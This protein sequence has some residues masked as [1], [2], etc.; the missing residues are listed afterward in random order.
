MIDLI[1]K[2]I[3]IVAD[4]YDLRRFGC[5]EKIVHGGFYKIG[6]VVNINGKELYALS[7]LL[8][9]ELVKSDMFIKK[10][11]PEEDDLVELAALRR[12]LSRCNC[13]GSSCGSSDENSNIAILG[14]LSSSIF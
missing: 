4:D 1:G 7:G 5:N 11:N 10:N 3:Q 12:E 9:G 13:S 6:K 14:A 8:D 2:S